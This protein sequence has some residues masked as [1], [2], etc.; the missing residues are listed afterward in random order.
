MRWRATVAGQGVPADEP[1]QALKIWSKAVTPE[2]VLSHPALAL[3]EL[4]RRFYF[5]NGYLAE[6]GF[7]PRSWL[8]RLNRTTARLM[9]EARVCTVSNEA[10]DL[11]PGHSA[12]Q[13][14]VRRFRALVDRDPIYWEFATCP[15]IL[16]LVADLVGPDIKFHSAKLNNKRANDGAA[17]H[18]HQDIQAWPH[19]N[20]SPVTIGIYLND[21][22]ASNGPLAVVPGSQD[23][24]LFDQYEGD[25]WTGYI[26]DQDLSQVDLLNADPIHGP[27]GTL[28]AINCRAIH[29]SEPN[30]GTRDR[31]M[32]LLVYASAD[33]MTCSSA[34]TPTTHTNEIV[35]GR[36]ARWS[37]VDPRPSLIPPDWEEVG[38]GSIF[39]AQGKT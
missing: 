24:P 5:S 30:S 9:D 22:G 19:T 2:D 23:G 16:D 26:S 21:V 1:T 14:H 12:E 34:P 3:S 17:V 15:L 25:R 29:G 36:P 4:A 32:I 38:Y 28:C 11:G 13:P 31:P 7:V 8:D 37:H 6:P 33:A 10:F 27:A 20:Y 39:T 35:R 18:W